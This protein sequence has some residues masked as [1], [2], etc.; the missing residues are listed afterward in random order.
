MKELDPVEGRQREITWKSCCKKV[1]FFAGIKNLISWSCLGKKHSLHFYSNFTF[2]KLNNKPGVLP[3]HV[4]KCFRATCRLVFDFFA[5]APSCAIR[6]S[7]STNKAFDMSALSALKLKIPSPPHL[8]QSV[9]CAQAKGLQYNGISYDHVRCASSKTRSV[10]QS[11]TRKSL[12]SLKTKKPCT[13]RRR[14]SPRI[15]SADSIQR[16]YPPAIAGYGKLTVGNKPLVL[17][18]LEASFASSCFRAPVCPK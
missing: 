16:V 8:S 12:H 11:N 15:W 18:L 17:M 10:C 14:R 6:S 7:S 1:C 9:V 2:R 13:K 3:S 5:I 4:T